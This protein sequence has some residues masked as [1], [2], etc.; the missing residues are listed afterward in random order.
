MRRAYVIL[1][2]LEDGTVDVYYGVCHSMARADELCYE[3]EE[4]DPDH[5]YTW[6]EIIEEDD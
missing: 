4:N 1:G 3:A 6:H 2:E 5:Y